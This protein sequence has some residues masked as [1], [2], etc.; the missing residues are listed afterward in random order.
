[1]FG[2][3]LRGESQESLSFLPGGLG[4]SVGDQVREDSREVFGCVARVKPFHAPRFLLSLEHASRV[5][6]RHFGLLNRP[7]LLRDSGQPPLDRAKAPRSAVQLD[8]RAFRNL[9]C[10][11][12]PA[13]D[14]EEAIQKFQ[15]RP[16]AFHLAIFDVMLPKCTGPEAYDRIRQIRPDL[17]AVFATGYSPDLSILQKVQQAGWPILQKPYVSRVLAR[18]V[19]ETLDQRAPAL[20]RE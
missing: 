10:C 14:G 3:A 12:W 15:E 5:A 9:H 18:I 16:D 17:P 7:R 4:I 11:L 20:P 2:R 13:V 6:P 8:L 19:R 1:M